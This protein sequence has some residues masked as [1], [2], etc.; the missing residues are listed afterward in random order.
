MNILWVEKIEL[1]ARKATQPTC[2]RWSQN[3]G[4]GVHSFFCMR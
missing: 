1:I 4:G 3:S 2:L